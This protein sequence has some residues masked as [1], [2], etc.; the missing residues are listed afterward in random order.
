MLKGEG[1]AHRRYIR[2][3]AP[4]VMRVMAS[5]LLRE[6]VIEPRAVARQVARML[7]RALVLDVEVL[8]KYKWMKSRDIG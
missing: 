6:G 4:W 8:E 1:W 7:S 2:S 5:F 3:F